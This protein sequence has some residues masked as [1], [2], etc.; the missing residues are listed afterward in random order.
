MRSGPAVEAEPDQR[1]SLSLFFLGF[2]CSLFPPPALPLCP[3]TR[4]DVRVCMRGPCVRARAPRRVRRVAVPKEREPREYVSILKGVAGGAETAPALATILHVTTSRSSNP[5]CN[6]NECRSPFP[7]PVGLSPSTHSHP[8]LPSRPV[9]SSSLHRGTN[10]AFDQLKRSTIT[11][12]S[13]AFAATSSSSSAS[14]LVP[15]RPPFLVLFFLLPLSIVSF[16]CIS[17]PFA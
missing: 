5:R 2:S 17:F 7:H 11:W 13:A 14:S 9:I 15:P 1:R 16:T 8:P 3:C 4:R 12:F 10:R 6:P